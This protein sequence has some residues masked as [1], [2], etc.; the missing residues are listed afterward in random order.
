MRLVTTRLNF[1]W[2]VY[3]EKNPDVRIIVA[4]TVGVGRWMA[5]SNVTF[6]QASAYGPT[7]QIRSCTLI[8]PWVSWLTVGIYPG[9]LSE[10]GWNH[11]PTLA[12]AIPPVFWIEPRTWLLYFLHCTTFQ[13]KTFFMSSYSWKVKLWGLICHT[14]LKQIGW[15][16]HVI[17]F[18]IKV[19]K[20]FISQTNLLFL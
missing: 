3:M 10:D 14:H 4:P 15:D 6:A 2:L 19:D 5:E 12:H 7:Q 1:A 11:C 20:H 17:L 18:K 13:A 9:T 8:I 16:Y